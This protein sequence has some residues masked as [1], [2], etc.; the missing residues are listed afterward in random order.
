MNGPAWRSHPR[1]DWRSLELEWQ[2]SEKWKMDA[3][4]FVS[5]AALRSRLLPA[6]V[7]LSAVPEKRSLSSPPSALLQQAI[8]QR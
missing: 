6:F 4:T 7:Y 5:M 3:E 2:L 8:C 1:S